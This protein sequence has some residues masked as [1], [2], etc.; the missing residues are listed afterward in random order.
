[1]P[2]SSLRRLHS[3]RSRV[4]R[5]VAGAMA[6]P[7]RARQQADEECGH[8]GQDAVDENG[9]DDC[10]GGRS[11]PASGRVSG[12]G[13]SHPGPVPLSRHTERSRSKNER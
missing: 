12:P 5:E 10:G 4:S 8:D 13:E 9:R 2:C 6:L 7:R 1:M 11:S 3:I